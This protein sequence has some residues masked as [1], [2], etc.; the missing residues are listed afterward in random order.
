MPIV[1]VR[2]DQ[3]NGKSFEKAVNVE[4]E[5]LVRCPKCNGRVLLDGKKVYRVSRILVGASQDLFVQVPVPYC[6]KCGEEIEQ[7]PPTPK[8]SG[9]M[10]RIK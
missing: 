8:K 4:D 9:T 10:T 6:A 1:N 2:I 5:N 3:G 7:T